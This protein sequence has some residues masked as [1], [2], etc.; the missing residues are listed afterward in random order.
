ML[1]QKVYYHPGLLLQDE[2]QLRAMFFTQNQGHDALQ[3]YAGVAMFAGYWPLIYS[4]TRSV[5][6]M[7]CFVFTAAYG[8]TWAKIVQ[9]FL[10]GRLQSS[11]NSSVAQMAEKYK[12]KTDAHYL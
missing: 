10:V 3:K 1:F 9:P 2:Q 12:I 6:P 11:L 5:K 4:V 8:L 7:G